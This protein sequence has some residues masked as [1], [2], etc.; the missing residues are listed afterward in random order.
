MHSGLKSLNSNQSKASLTRPN[1]VTFDSQSIHQSTK[2][3]RGWQHG[4]ETPIASNLVKSRRGDNRDLMHS[5]DS[6]MS[7]SPAKPIKGH[8]PMLKSHFARNIEI[9]KLEPEIP[10]QV[11]MS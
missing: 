4:T 3:E 10:D 8:L 1:N 6:D 11:E 5:F 7:E 2:Y 9:D